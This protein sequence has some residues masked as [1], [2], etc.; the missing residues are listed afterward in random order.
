MGKQARTHTRR[1]VRSLNAHTTAC[2]QAS[3]RSGLRR[4]SPW[5]QAGRLRRG[6]FILASAA[7]AVLLHPVDE[8]FAADIEILGRLCLIAVEAI[9]GP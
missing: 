3:A 9:Q 1:A 8:R 6:F 4:R 2:F 7:N 5:R